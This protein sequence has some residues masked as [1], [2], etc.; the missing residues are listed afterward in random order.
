[1]PDD[2]S[3]H[4]IIALDLIDSTNAEAMRRAAAGERGPVWIMAA[5][6]THG[7]GRSGRAWQST[8]GNLAATLLIVPGGP[9]P[10]LYQ[11][12]LVTG[13]AVHDALA[14]FVAAA[15]GPPL[16]LKWPNDILLGAAKLGGILVETTTFAGET[17]AAIGIGINLAAAPRLPDRATCCLADFAPA[18]LPDEVL[19]AISTKM[20]NWLGIWQ[21]GAGVHVIR[22]GF[23]DR[24]GPIGEAISVKTGDG[25]AIG[26]YAGI[27]ETGAL[28]L[29]GRDEI[30]GQ[31]RRFTFGDVSVL[32]PDAAEG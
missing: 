10:R 19:A 21:G 29:Q 13:I 8:A 32:P 25:V 18:P 28:L 1:M 30:P 20:E 24:A 3:P 9:L 15:P 6:Q 11:L 22:T 16:R 17:V 14:P 23:L 2:V 27:D 31:V 7:R 5:R 26:A 12:A 4:R